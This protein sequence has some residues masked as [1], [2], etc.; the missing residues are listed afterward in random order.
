MTCVPMAIME[1]IFVG[2]EITVLPFEQMS[3]LTSL[4][5]LDVRRS[6]ITMIPTM[7]S[8]KPHHL[9]VDTR[10]SLVSAWHVT[11]DVIQVFLSLLIDF[12]VLLQLQHLR[13]M[14]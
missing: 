3:H 12:R 6:D 2:S 14:V 10:S 4:D 9:T 13:S 8:S 5:T 7:C 11:V 1:I